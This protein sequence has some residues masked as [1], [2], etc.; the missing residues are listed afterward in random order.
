MYG[1]LLG[2]VTVIFRRPHVFVTSKQL[3]SSDPPHLQVPLAACP[4]SSRKREDDWPC[5]TRNDGAQQ[6]NCMANVL[7]WRGCCI[8]P[9]LCIWAVACM[10]YVCPFSGPSTLKPL[11]SGLCAFKGWRLGSRH[12]RATESGLVQLKN[13]SIHVFQSRCATSAP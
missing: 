10:T 6:I 2:A 12:H 4:A 13:G 11:R 5:L 3:A 9:L 7:R 8:T 1:L